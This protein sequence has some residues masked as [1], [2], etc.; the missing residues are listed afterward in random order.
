MIEQ[1]LIVALL[2]VLT[3]YAVIRFIIWKGKRNAE[4]AR[5]YKYLYGYID[6][7]IDSMSVNDCN[8]NILES[9]LRDLDSLTHRFDR[10]ATDVLR[11][12]FYRKFGIVASRRALDNFWKNRKKKNNC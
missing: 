8:Y 2:V 6:G 12:K 5:K 11:G 3:V 1:S 7:H 10:E 9:G 4:R